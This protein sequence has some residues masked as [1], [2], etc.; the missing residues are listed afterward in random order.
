MAGVRP[1]GKSLTMLGSFAGVA[2]ILAILAVSAGFL[3]GLGWLGFRLGQETGAVWFVGVGCYSL[4]K[5]VK[6]VWRNVVIPSNESFM[7][8]LAEHMKEMERSGQIV[9]AK[10]HKGKHVHR[11]KYK[12]Q[13]CGRRNDAVTAMDERYYLPCIHCGYPH[14]LFFKG[15]L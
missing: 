14:R 10:R 4:Y 5:G 6:W 11:V 7:K 15:W 3:Y 8:G 13:R 12:C 2:L 9:I 1:P